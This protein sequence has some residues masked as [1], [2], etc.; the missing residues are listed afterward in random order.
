MTRGEALHV[1]A[2]KVV[3][4]ALEG[5]MGCIQELANR[6]MA[7]RRRASRLVAMRIHRCSISIM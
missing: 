3:L 2:Q 7:G 1:I 4:G 5:D 6:W